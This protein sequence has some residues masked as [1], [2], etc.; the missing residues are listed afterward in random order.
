MSA[1]IRFRGEDLGYQGR[2]VL[3]GLELTVTAGQRIALLGRSGAGKSTLITAIY[4]RLVSAGTA[5]AL[6]PQDH[7]LVPQLSVFHNIY[8]GRLERHGAL[9]NLVNLARPMR[10]E[11]AQVRPVAATLGLE[12]ELFRPVERLSGGQRQRV[13]VGRALHRGGTV[14]LAD[15]PVSAVDEAQGRTLVD[16]MRAHFTTLVLAVHAVE[17]ATEFADRILGLRGGRVV[18]DTLASRI[19]RADLDAIYAT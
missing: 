13:A 5:V 1:L 14:L 9:Y 4:R 3:A 2:T 8:M 11:V 15:E 10:S 7:A 17:L 12:P 18:V 19:T 6:V 16:V